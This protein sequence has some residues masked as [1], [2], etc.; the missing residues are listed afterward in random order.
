MMLYDIGLGSNREQQSMKI[1]ESSLVMRLV[2]F[3]V[4]VIQLS[5]MI[6][7]STIKCFYMYLFAHGC[8]TV[9]RLI[10]KC[11]SIYVREVM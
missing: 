10:M 6:V 5:M 8:L 9:K 4:L 7:W 3:V 11:S 2:Y 1:D